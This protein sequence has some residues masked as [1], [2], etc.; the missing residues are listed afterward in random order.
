M[1]PDDL[2]VVRE[3][4]SRVGRGDLFEWMEEQAR[5]LAGL[6]RTADG[7]VRVGRELQR[8]CYVRSV[9]PSRI[10]ARAELRVHED[11]F[12]IVFNRV[13]SAEVQR[14][15]IAHEIGHT[16]WMEVVPGEAPRDRY[17]TAGQGSRTIEM[18]CDYFAAALLM[19]RDDVEEVLRLHRKAKGKGR[20][21]NEEQRCPLEL[22]PG[23]A[24][25]FRVQR[26]IAA[27][28]LLLV[29]KLSSW[30][31]VRVQNG[32]AKARQ[33]LLE[34][35]R[36]DSDAWETA[37]YETGSVRRKGTIVEGYRAPFDT[38]RRRIPREMIPQDVTAET[39]LQKLDSRW[40]DGVEPE[41]AARARVPFGRRWGNRE[42]LGLA[43][44]I[45]NSVY[46]AIDRERRTR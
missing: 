32:F 5:Y 26:R 33:P 28:R 42:P 27:W 22:V 1:K 21:S 38:R 25:R 23:L 45:E 7:T 13:V 34:S 39:R 43:A 44:R 10:S 2:P 3:L 12:S 6:G 41:P 18:L 19:P 35:Q 17:T 37:W 40:W 14:F 46:V 16:L 36:G 8:A 31:I 11:C 20:S 29:Q 4:A 30:V 9:T 15:S 24:R